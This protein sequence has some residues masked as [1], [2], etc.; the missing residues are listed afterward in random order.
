M[1]RNTPMNVMVSK[2]AVKSAGLRAVK[3]SAK[4]EGR[5]RASRPPPGL[6]PPQRTCAAA[7]DE[8]TPPT[9]ERGDSLS[10]S[11]K[12][13]PQGCPRSSRSRPN[14]APSSGH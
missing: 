12:Y 14:R 11:T 1:Q 10:R 5:S 9:H 7:A 8:L 6:R 3:A 4:L 2:A 13:S